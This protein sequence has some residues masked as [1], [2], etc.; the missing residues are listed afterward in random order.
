[1]PMGNGQTVRY[2]S[3]RSLVG[4]VPAAAGNGARALFMPP[5]VISAQ[6]PEAPRAGDPNRPPRPTVP[7]AA[8]EEP[9]IELDDVAPDSG[10]AP[11]APAVSVASVEDSGAKP[12]LAPTVPLGV[13]T[14]AG[15]AAAGD[16]S[17]AAQAEAAKGAGMPSEEE[18]EDE[19]A[20][21][22]KRAA[23]ESAEEAA[24]IVE[25]DA[26]TASRAGDAPER[27]GT[28][29]V[30]GGGDAPNPRVIVQRW[31]GGVSRASAGLPRRNMSAV[32]AGPAKITSA[33]DKANAD[34][35]G[36]TKGVAA[37]AAANVSQPPKVPDP[38]P[39][40][41]SNP[42]PAHTAAIEAASNKK[43]PHAFLPELVKSA[44][45]EVVP[46]MKVGGNM[47]RIGDRTVKDKWFQLLSTEGAEAAAKI[48]EDPK[49]PERQALE[50][51]RAALAKPIEAQE[52][53]A[54]GPPSPLIDQGPQGI[55][56]LPP[57]KGTPVAKVV[58]RLLASIG[59]ATSDLLVRLRR[60]AYPNGVLLKEFPEI[61]A[62]F[63]DTV[64]PRMSTEL[65]E[66]A[67]AAGVSSAELDK[68]V[69]ERKTELGKEAADA[70][71]TIA[72]SHEKATEGVSQTGQEALDAI[73]GAR[74]LTDEEIIKRQEAATGGS[75][76]EVIN[77]RRDLVIRWVRT[78]VNGQTTNYQKAGEKREQELNQAQQERVE[79]I[80]SLAQREEY[81]GL[82]PPSPYVAHDRGKP[83]IVRKLADFTAALR[84]AAREAVEKLRTAMRSLFTTAR[85]T[86]R[87]NRAAVEKAGNEAID[88]AR[89]WA[90][91]RILEGQS[92][93][94]RFK[95]KLS[96]WL[97]DSQKANEQWYVN[98]TE[99]TRNG[100]ST[101]LDS[102][103]AIQQAVAQGATKEQLLQSEGLT[104]DQR[105]VVTEYFAQPAGAHPLDIAAGA[106]RQRLAKQYL[107]VAKPVFEAELLAKPDGELAKVAEV[108]H[109]ARPTFNGPKIAQDV[110]AQLDNFDS[111]ESAMLR[112]LEGLSAFEGSLVRRLY[113][114]MFH[115]DMD[116]AMAQAFDSDEMDQAKLRLEG[117]G[118][119]ADAA[120]LDYAFGVINTDEKAIMDLLRGRSQED[121]EKIRAEYKRRYGKD[122]DQALLDNLD[123]GNEQEQAKALMKGDKEAAD[124]IEI[125]EAMRGGLF[126]WGTKEEDIEATYKRVHDEVL[127]QAQREGWS[128]ALMQAEIRRR[129]G[130]I[131]KEFED[132]YKHVEQY[133]E[134]GLEGKSAL[135][136][137]FSSE[138]DPGPE[139]DLANALAD[140]D[141]VKADAARIEIERRG[142]WASDEAINKVLSNQYE[143]ALE[144][145][146]LDLAPARKI[147][148]DRKRAELLS[149]KPPPTENEMSI[150]MIKLERELDKDA[151]D[152]A[153][154]RSNVSMEA[155]NDAYQKKYFYPLSYTIEANMSG[156]DLEKARALHKQGGRL[157]AL[158]EVDYATKG[159]GTDEEALRT[160]I[161]GMT[162]AE[163][164]KLREDWEALHPGESFDDMLRG[165]LSGRDESDIMDMVKYGAP[166]SANERIDQEQRRV[167]RELG[168]LTGALGGA[169]AGKEADWVTQQMD[170]LNELKSDLDRRDL[171]DE[172]RE[173]LRDQLDYRVELVQQGVEDHRRAIDSVANFAAQVASLVVAVAVGAALTFLSGGTLGP[174]M[175]AVIASV[176]A[177]VTTM[178]TKAL[179]QGGSYGAE[180][181]GVDLAVGVV[182]ALTAAATAG[183]GGKLLRGATGAAEQ[184]AVRAAQPNRFMRFLGKA[185]GSEV[186]QGV[187]KSRAGQVAGKVA[188]GLNTMESGF[189]TRGIKGTNALARM[190]QG[191]SKALRLLAEGL[192]EGIENAVSALPSSFA[193][194]ALN[195]KTWEGNPLLNLA[196]G[197]YEGVKGAVQL[198]AVM[199]GARGAY[200]AVSSHVRLSTP[201]GRL[202]EAN[203]ILNEAR[204][205]HR[206]KNPNATHQDFLSSPEARRAQA[207]IEQRGLIGEQRKLAKA[208]EPEAARTETAARPDAAPAAEPKPEAAAHPEAK[209]EPAQRAAAEARADE[210]APTAKGAV[211]SAEVAAPSAHP[212]KAVD[213][214]TQALR[215]G[216]PKSLADRVDVRVNDKLD[217]NS[218]HVI[219]DPR[220]PGHGVRVEVGP[221]A[222]PTDVLLHA[223]T[224]QTMQRYQ[225]L[226]GKLR[227]LKDWFNLTTVGTR[228]WEAKLELEKLPGIIHERM[229]RLAEGGLTPEAHQKVVGEIN[230]LSK[231]I[232]AHQKVL[233]TPELREQPGRGFVAAEGE[234]KRQAAKELE[235]VAGNKKPDRTPEAFAEYPH[236]LVTNSA[237]EGRVYQLGESWTE[238]GRVYRRV[239]TIDADGKTAHVREEIQ[240]IDPKTGRG[241]DHWV[242]RGS[243]SSGAEGKGAVGEAASRI[244]I[245]KGAFEGMVDVAGRPVEAA[246]AAAKGKSR[247]AI[248]ENNLRNASNNGFDGVFLRENV[249]GTFSV[250]LVEAKNQPSGLTKASFSAVS[251]HRLQ[252][253]IDELV[254]KLVNEPHNF[255]TLSPKQRQLVAD[256][257]KGK[258]GSIEVQ[259][260]TTPETKL[261]HREHRHSSILE[262]LETDAN[263]GRAKNKQIKF[264]HVPMTPEVTKAAVAEVQARDAIGKPSERLKELAGDKVKE[265]TVEHKQA[266]SMLLAEGAFTSGLAS[267]LAP[268]QFVDEAKT[269]FDVVTPGARGGRRPRAETVAA[270]IVRRLNAPAPLHAK[271]Q[272]KV[273]ID[274]SHLDPAKQ[275]EVLR[276]LRD[277]KPKS[278][279]KSVLVHDREGGRMA[280]FDPESVK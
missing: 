268:G 201:E 126:G 251:E 249:D 264:V 279:L 1:M 162:K 160:R 231:Q 224:I 220:G 237:L 102:V 151:G 199:H 96:R 241:Q 135:R 30:E 146:R 226:L 53:Q 83:E 256:I 217:G 164:K 189:L 121:I 116:F 197:T 257:L 187:A 235:A 80:N 6:A 3:S 253:N 7:D 54:I 182:D 18:L 78:H 163:I 21:Q 170:R 82:H 60:M 209:A 167:N 265:G 52:A 171:T 219:P 10:V 38:P 106:L 206:A 208:G 29:K 260:H 262:D 79:A 239:F 33:A 138:M 124:A 215:D 210:T 118:A 222:T 244:T 175:I 122:L 179:I 190:A 240:S 131:E 48:P 31:Q 12:R 114:A 20:G 117:K 11:V 214:A 230:H 180:D 8:A 243:E 28:E 65:R 192:A 212:D 112:S 166:E 258:Q 87:D 35:R 42:I 81:Q 90:E 98:R 234:G 202:T 223:H 172:E 185:G 58:A 158:Q 59:S 17:T 280:I 105:S 174:V 19:S 195:D 69:A 261:G 269:L 109:I 144:E 274:L 149:R 110:H 74:Q 188:S 56:P 132:R 176:A 193:G 64:S 183:M 89:L 9:V 178:G 205:Q 92:W 142:V 16:A 248:E 44:E 155:L 252:T 277:V 62:A 55:A 229:Q 242:Q 24:E 181:I 225:G 119:A 113:R 2:V 156:V 70:Q 120:A 246:V 159:T 267:P 218:V 271:G 130:R 66:I 141:T 63:G 15:A 93:W 194:T 128:S 115:V 111:D 227:Q 91:D 5:G 34:R 61:G 40:P 104:E 145:T 43:L 36:K 232:D 39:P 129:L 161:G 233:D 86:T 22:E 137:A 49:T 27:A 198:G 14:R 103:A 275:R 68:M 207:E 200:G 168:E 76:P 266:Q 25:L 140:N 139:R 148:V 125:D 169:A 150:E 107:E 278:L 94:E 136:R 270:D 73:E 77:A 13:S 186:M 216:L 75:D 26:A 273:I 71:K 51:A 213:P 50:N 4:Q 196:A 57:G 228:G 108:A 23:E 72:A 263:K 133:N 134:P 211:S 276:L 95:A 101:D 41:K 153:Q 165:E 191:D 250:V 32:A 67:A 45:I 127:A 221:H 173:L 85:D 97:G 238:K 147:I 84:A 154:K 259:I 184:A 245:E 236:T 247:I 46:G 255:N 99:E 177:T 152:E 203:R 100:I 204:E 88:A 254:N 272:R 37:D 123:E 47:P 143:R 157:T